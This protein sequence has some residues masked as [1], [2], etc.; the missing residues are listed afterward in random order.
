MIDRAGRI[1]QFRGE[2]VCHLQMNSHVV[3][4]GKRFFI[5]CDGRLV[6]SLSCVSFRALFRGLL[7]ASSQTQD[8]KKPNKSDTVYVE[9]T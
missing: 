8:Q 7:V 9:T 4:L 1:V 5:V 3:A 2:Q 6:S